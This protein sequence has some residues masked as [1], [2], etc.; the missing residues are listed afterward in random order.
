MNPKNKTVI[1]IIVISAVLLVSVSPYIFAINMRDV[2][3]L[4]IKVITNKS[5]YVKG[6]TVE[7]TS[8]IIN[9]RINAMILQSYG[10]TYTI[11]DED[12]QVVFDGPIIMVD[13][14]PNIMISPYSQYKLPDLEWDQKTKNEEQT[15]SGTYKIIVLFNEFKGESII[16]IV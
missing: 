4:K 10:L 2:K 15:P 16:Q 13:V 6:E 14:P 5:I 11:E 1:G 8:Y 9:D 3:D 7:I 12:G